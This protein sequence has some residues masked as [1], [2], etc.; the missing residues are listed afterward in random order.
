M[1]I[2]LVDWVLK[3]SGLM[4]EKKC[5][6]TASFSIIFNGTLV[7]YFHGSRGLRQADPLSPFLFLVV[8]EAF[9]MLLEKAFQGGLK[10]GL[11]VG[12]NGDVVSH[13]QFVDEYSCIVQ[14]FEEA[15]EIFKTCN[16]MF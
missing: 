1:I 9:S 4:D 12:Q 3:V 14:R 7:E 13:L 10:E 11:K 6:G 5:Y 15:T 16:Q 2:C 8:V